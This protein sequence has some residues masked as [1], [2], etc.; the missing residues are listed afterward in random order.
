MNALDYTVEQLQELSDE[1]L[2]KLYDEC[3]LKEDFYHIQQYVKKIMINSLYGS[4]GNKNFILFNEKVAQAITG[5][6]RFL[7]QNTSR[8]INDALNSINPDK[9]QFVGIVYNDTDSCVGDTN[10]RT[11]VGNIKIEDLFNSSNGETIVTPNGSFVKKVKDTILADS[12]SENFELQQNQITYIM[13]HHVKKR[14]YKIKCNGKE[15][16]ITED[17]SIM[18]NRNGKLISVKPKDILKT[19]MLITI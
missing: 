14:M 6:G 8:M 19:D 1:E 7:V 13:K 3:H 16:I 17:H 10:I 2:E 15:V 11:S 18:T 9:S 5:N 12:V 4:V